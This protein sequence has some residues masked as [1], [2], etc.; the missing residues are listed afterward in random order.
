M[1][2][3]NPS[4]EPQPDPV[5]V[6]GELAHW[7][8]TT[9]VHIFLGLLI[10]TLAARRMRARHLH[11][12]WAAMVLVLVVLARTIFA[13]A[14]LTLSVAAGFAAARSRR[15]HHEDLTAGGDLA[16][17]AA[18]RSHP[19][20]C[21]H[22]MAGLARGRCH[23]HAAPDSSAASAELML[24]RDER[25]RAVAI[26]FG[27]AHG[28]THALVLGATGSG[29]T[30]TQTSLVV[31]AIARGMGAVVID[32]KGDS[33]LRAHL[34]AGAHSAGRAFL[35]WTPGGET[36][37]NPYARGSET[38]I[39]DKA[40]AAER[41]TEPHYQRQAQ[42]YLGHAVRAMRLVG[43]EVSLAGI[44]RHLDPERLEELARRLPEEQA[45]SAHAYLDSL[46]P[47]QQSE[48]TGVRDR[49]AILTE[50]DVGRWLDPET[51][52]AQQFDLLDAVRSRA[53]VY[54]G[55]ESDSRPLL[56][57]MLGGAVVA[58]L[59]T[60][61]ASLQGQPV[62]TMVVIDEFSAVA[63]EQIVRL[64]GRARSAGMS[65]LLG[66]QELS[67]LRLPGRE[68]LL[69]QVMGNL[70][71]L[72]AH[73]QVV[74]ASAELIAGVAGRRGAWKVSRS[75]DGRS[76]RTRTTEPVLRPDRVMRLGQGWGAVI[77][78]GAPDGARITR[79]FPP[80]QRG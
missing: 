62:A 23:A 50:S 28:G 78:P 59:Q 75:S 56:S 6:I 77:V 72:V 49:L 64:F 20:D 15:W 19:L 70:S 53:V 17:I 5:R 18:N 3:P 76:T 22:R 58:D 42:R 31:A 24:G 4:P 79:V 69:E 37:Y 43:D 44:V 35:Q 67:D 48:L 38:E 1:S 74:P 30:V 32:P 80:E 55:L 16:E 54:F 47:R 71:V 29:K 26:P 8:S 12:S 36:V 66:T 41:F 61:V 57:Q 25:G 52:G 63:A 60:V 51:A 11:W 7:T 21:L 46:T 65:L 45:R 27:G 9:A 14:T 68:R 34:A 13:G 40:L 2:M 73:R 33:S 39:A 10:G